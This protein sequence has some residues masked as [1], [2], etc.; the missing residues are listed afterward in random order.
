[1]VRIGL[2]GP[3]LVE[4]DGRAQVVP[5]PTQRRALIF[6]AIHANEVVSTDQLAD[7]VW[8]DHPP[9]DP[10]H[11]IHS[12]VHRLR[13]Q[14]TA[15]DGVRLT[16]AR[17]DP[18]YALEIDPHDIDAN[19]FCER[20]ERA[21]SVPSDRPS[22][23]ADVLSGALGLW[24]GDALLDV[25]YESWAASEIRRLTE[26]RVSACETLARANLDLGRGELAISELE[27]LTERFPLRESLWLLLWEALAQAGRHL[28]VTAS[29][30]RALG[31][32]LGDYGIDASDHLARAAAAFATPLDA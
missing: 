20:V 27:S 4:I 23:I 22:D 19:L 26:L 9:S 25:A 12:L 24:R 16:I 7:A 10:R 18:G 1:M 2:L 14:V 21:R 11:A 5:S 15:G 30:R 31:V 28:E 17:R 29:Y 32:L 3:L 8:C 6:L 13:H